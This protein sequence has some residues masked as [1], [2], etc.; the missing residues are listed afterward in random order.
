MN[1]TT[2][3]MRGLLARWAEMEPNLCEEFPCVF[4]I[5]TAAGGY[6]GRVLPNDLSDFHLAWIQWAVQAAIAEREWAF[7]LTYDN[8]SNLRYSAKVCIDKDNC[9]NLGSEDGL[10]EAL[11]ATYLRALEKTR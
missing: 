11:L 4:T 10:T 3:K 6:I 2:T 5:R 1:D 8:E 7:T 9:I